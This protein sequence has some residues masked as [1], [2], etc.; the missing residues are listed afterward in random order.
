MT[1]PHEP[2]HTRR[3]SVAFQ[4]IPVVFPSYSRRIPV[5]FPSQSHSRRIPVAIFRNM[6]EISIS[7]REFRAKKAE[8]IGKIHHNPVFGPIFKKI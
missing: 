5:V 2:A 1:E 4:R 7:H 6:M 3:F 8:C